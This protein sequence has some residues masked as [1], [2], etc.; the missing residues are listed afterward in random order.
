M[1]HGA[2]AA[3]R[4][5]KAE[6]HDGMIGVGAFAGPAAERAAEA[7]GSGALGEAGPGQ[8]VR[9]RGLPERPAA[10]NGRRKHAALGAQCT[11]RLRRPQ[12]GVTKGRRRTSTPSRVSKESP[13]ARVELE[14]VRSASLPR[15]FY[16]GEARSKKTSSRYS[17]RSAKRRLIRVHRSLAGNNRFGISGCRISWF[18]G[19]ATEFRPEGT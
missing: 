13:P 11:G 4:V 9:E 2:G 14:L 3:H 5:G 17:V 15:W 18:C 1:G 16:R 10:P 12:G 8:D 7:V 19:Q 6:F